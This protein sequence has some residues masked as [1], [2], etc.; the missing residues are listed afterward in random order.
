MILQQLIN[1]GNII[2]SK[3]PRGSCKCLPRVE[4]VV[5][6]ITYNRN[7][8][9]SAFPWYNFHLLYTYL[10]LLYMY[11]RLIIYV[12]TNLTK[13][14]SRK[15]NFFSCLGC[16]FPAHCHR[17]PTRSDIVSFRKSVSIVLNPLLPNPRGRWELPQPEVNIRYRTAVHICRRG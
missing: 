11:L 12:S 9:V 14:Q 10:D 4:N 2:L 13:N 17:T 3:K 7:V 15:C 1:N 6:L 16:L 8:T 5:C